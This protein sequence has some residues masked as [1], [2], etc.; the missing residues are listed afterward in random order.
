MQSATAQCSTAALRGYGGKISRTTATP[1]VNLR[2]APSR[3]APILASLPPGSPVVILSRRGREW[4]EVVAVTPAP[5]C[6]EALG[7]L[8]AEF[9]R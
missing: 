1:S 2:T 9:V 4:L 5:A 7:Y 8:V 3:G 6:G